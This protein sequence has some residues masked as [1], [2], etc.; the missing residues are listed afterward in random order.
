MSTLIQH[1]IDFPALDP[2]WLQAPSEHTPKFA[3][4]FIRVSMALQAA[5]RNHL[6]SAYFADLEHF[7]DVQ[8]AYS[9]L[10]YQ[11]S[12]VFRGKIRTDL[13]RDVMNQKM[14]ARMVRMARANLTQQL[15]QT[16]ARLRAAGLDELAAQYS[17]KRLRYIMKSVQRLHRSRRCLG[18]LVRG[19]GV[20]LDAL[21]QLCGLGNRTRA[22]QKRRG[23]L[24][25]KKWTVQLRRLYPKRNFED[26]APVLLDAA[27]QALRSCLEAPADSSGD[28]ASARPLEPLPAGS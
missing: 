26:F 10:V 6:P 23:T 7:R 15:I 19:E 13:T 5:L 9:I 4:V 27:T 17:R 3:E 2:C 28:P 14:M 8:S 25:K 1:T 12:R 22:E 21:V 18:I 20:L 11:S 24:L 16:E